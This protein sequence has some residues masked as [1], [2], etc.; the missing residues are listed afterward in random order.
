MI[1]FIQLKKKKKKK[2]NKFSSMRSQQILT[3][4][5][6]ANKLKLKVLTLNFGPQHP[7]AHGVLRLLLKLNNELIV[8]CDPNIGLLHRGTEKLMEDKIYINSLPYFD[9]LDYVSTLLQE[10][11]YVINIETLSNKKLINLEEIKTRTVFDELTRILNHYLAIAC[12]A[13]DVGS[14]SPIFWAFEDREKIMEFYEYFSGARMHT[15]AYKPLYVNRCLNNNLKK[16]ILYYLNNSRSTLNE[17]H[18]TLSMNKIW[19]LRLKNNGKLNINLLEQYGLTGILSRCIG[20]KR[21][22]RLSN[23]TTYNNYFFLKMNSYIAKNG[24]SYDRFLLRLYEISES[25]N[26]INQNI[27]YV[28][29]IE[30]LKFSSSL[31][32]KI[33]NKK[34][35]MEK[36]IE[37]F[38]YWS[39]GFNIK[40]NILYR[41]IESSKGEFGVILVS[42]N[43]NKPYRCKIRSPSFHNLYL[44]T[45]LA[46]NTFIADLI[47]LIGTIDIVFGEVDR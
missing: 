27:V 1:Q 3:L 19:K 47:V 38:K 26:I 13:L 15:A 28:H 36:M 6:E 31:N 29:E 34:N 43:T 12:H 10:H 35:C 45:S 42:D 18:N 9:R 22:L 5:N 16:N 23:N 14:M 21:D 4:K 37:H 2:K 20:F 17:I 7:A 24:D 11:A 33:F 30:S 25:L 32:E 44:L 46:K 8:E 41:P 39:S 40:S